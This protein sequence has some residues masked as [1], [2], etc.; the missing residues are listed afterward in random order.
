MG[1]DEKVA[2]PATMCPYLKAT[3]GSPWTGDVDSDC[4]PGPCG[5]HRGGR[6]IAGDE[7]HLITEGLVGPIPPEDMWPA[8]PH[9]DACKWQDQTNGPCG[10][11]YALMMG[12]SVEEVGVFG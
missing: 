4:E 7:F 12:L 3:Q 6:C 8:C 11:R 5:W 9:A 2:C 10:P 1:D